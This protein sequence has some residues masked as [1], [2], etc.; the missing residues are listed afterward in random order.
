[1]ITEKEVNLK[2]FN[3][4]TKTYTIDKKI[5]YFTV[6]S[7]HIFGDL[8]VIITEPEDFSITLSHYLAT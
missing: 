1:M 2:V 4:T 8:F 3:T 5:D 6:I 7:S